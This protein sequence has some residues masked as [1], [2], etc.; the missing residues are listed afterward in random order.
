MKED[1]MKKRKYSDCFYCGGVV[2]EQLI[3]RE[4][5]WKG[6]LIIIEEVPVGVCTQCGEKMLKPEVVKAVDLV[7]QKKK[8]PAKTIEVP[9]YRYSKVA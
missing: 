1:V 9:V 4:I 2:E 3:P 7:L 8:E 6:E 5:R